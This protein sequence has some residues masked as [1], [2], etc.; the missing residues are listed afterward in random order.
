LPIKN[1]STP[2]KFARIAL[3]NLFEISP[4]A[5]VVTD[6]DGIIREANPRST[7]LFGYTHEELIGKRVDELVPERLRGRH[8]SHREN[9]N[10]HPRERQMGAAMDLSGLRKDGTEVPVDIM[11]KP[12]ETE[13]G[14][15]VLSFVRDATEQRAA[16]D[17]IRSQDQ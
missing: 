10:A 8:P 1:L 16:Q 12:L 6:A 14:P 17:V 7:A 11:L 2:S 13:D 9:Y 4:D 5:I 15:A 3:E